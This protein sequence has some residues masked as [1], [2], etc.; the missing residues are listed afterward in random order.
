MNNVIKVED[1]QDDKLHPSRLYPKN[2]DF[3]I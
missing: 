1:F 2:A 3:T